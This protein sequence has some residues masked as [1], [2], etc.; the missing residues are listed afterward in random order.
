M[1]VSEIFNNELFIRRQIWVYSS[2][3]ATSMAF[4]LALFSA[5]D[6]VDT[7]LPLSMSIYAF[8]ISLTVNSI[9]AFICVGFDDEIETLNDIYQ[10]SSFK[11]VPILAFLSFI[12]S[13]LFL[14]AHFSLWS[15]CFA[16]F[17]GGFI[18]NRLGDGLANLTDAKDD[19]Q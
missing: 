10:N 12:V 18:F 17:T 1:L 5:G 15:A 19:S 8:T 11:L 2:F 3:A 4:F 9:L 7:S 14:L 13:V 16:L 6:K